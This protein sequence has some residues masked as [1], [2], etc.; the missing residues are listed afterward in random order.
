MGLKALHVNYEI[1]MSQLIS[2]TSG[3]IP[4]SDNLARLLVS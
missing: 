1:A 4:V 2:D 3:A